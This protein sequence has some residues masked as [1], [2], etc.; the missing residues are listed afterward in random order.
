LASPIPRSAPF[1]FA[2]P[3]HGGD[4]F[5]VDG[6]LDDWSAH[7]RLPT[8]SLGSPAFAEVSAAWSPDGMWFALRVPRTKAPRV[9]PK[10]P[11]DGDC[12]E[13]YLDTRDLR[14]A[15]R[16]GRYCHKFVLAP[17][18]G[19]GQA[20][21]PLFEHQEMPRALATPPLIVPDQIEIASDVSGYEYSME[22][23]VPSA[24]LSGYDVDATR[25]LGLAY[26]LHD[27]EHTV[28]TWPHPV[29]LPVAS[30]PSFWATVELVP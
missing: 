26:V 12:L 21:R 14:N 29:G 7:Y 15:H 10:R 23:F 28:Q 20:R 9:L 4:G 11:T 25:R 22:L 2:V 30:D 17:V 13:L 3:I 8:V 1:T 24:A 6:R 16:A 19:V 5:T 27:I 18:G